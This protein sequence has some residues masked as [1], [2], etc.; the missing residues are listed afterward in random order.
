MIYCILPFSRYCGLA[1]GNSLGLKN[2]FPG[3]NPASMAL[4]CHSLCVSG[5]TADS[6]CEGN[7]LLCLGTSCCQGMIARAS[8]TALRP[9]DIGVPV[10]SIIATEQDTG[11][12]DQADDVFF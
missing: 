6:F 3:S 2:S 9:E 8:E 11:G 10:I 12:I 7:T 4:L 1:R 5:L